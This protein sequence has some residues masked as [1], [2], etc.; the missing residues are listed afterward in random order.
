M[1]GPLREDLTRISTRSSVKDLYRIMQGPL[2]EE[3]SRI[4]TRASLRENLHEKRRT[5]VSCQPA[6]SKC[7]WTFGACAS[8]CSR[9]GHGH[10]TGAIS[11]ENL[12]E[13]GRE[14]KRI[15]WSNPGLNSYRKN[16][17]GGHTVCGIKCYYIT[18]ST[19]FRRPWVFCD[20]RCI[21]DDFWCA[22]ANR[23][24]FAVIFKAVN[25]LFW[26]IF[27]KTCISPRRNYH[28]WGFWEFPN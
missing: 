23:I 25:L 5:R 26:C 28:F 10:V 3:F 8:L 12:Q 15:P 19:A 6:Q 18:R 14:A 16:P 17:S 1:Q 2:R 9:N 4:S 20:Q 11:R 22:R 27:S 21:M 24:L 13:K 7:T